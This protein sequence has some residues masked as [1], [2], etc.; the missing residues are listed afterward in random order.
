M[1]TL[2]I[3]AFALSSCLSVSAQALK[4]DYLFEY[5]RQESHKLALKDPCLCIEISGDSFCCY[6]QSKFIRDSVAQAVLAETDNVYEAIE[7]T[8]K[9]PF[10]VA[11]FVFGQPSMGSFREIAQDAFV[12]LEGRGEYVQ[13]S[14][15]LGTETEVICG[16]SCQ[17]AVADYLGRTWTIW[18]TNEIPINLGP[19]L[20]WGA[21]GLIL[22]AEDGNGLFRFTLEK[23]GY[24]QHSRREQ[25][26]AKLEEEKQNPDPRY[27]EYDLADM[28]RLL[29]RMKRDQSVADEMTGGHTE[30][31]DANGNKID[32]S[33]LPYI[34]LIPDEYWNN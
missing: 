24:T 3:L 5:T 7:Q 27:Y 33:N 29:T 31:Y 8:R 21:P 17:K 20:L 16:Y 34:P 12:Y 13:P 25:I 6:S 9:Y 32:T 19:W 23:I 18:F 26:E 10:G 4:C 14:W 15:E 2:I 11:W 30:A 1:R 28:E 22:K